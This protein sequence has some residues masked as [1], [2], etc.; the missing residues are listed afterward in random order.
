MLLNVLHHSQYAQAQ[1]IVPE[2]THVDYNIKNYCSLMIQALTTSRNKLFNSYL[3][4]IVKVYK[5]WGI[6]VEKKSQINF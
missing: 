2:K 5:Y 6:N 1:R 3:N 4:D